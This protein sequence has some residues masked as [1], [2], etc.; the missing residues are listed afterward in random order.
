LKVMK[1]KRQRRVSA[2]VLGSCMPMTNGAR[3]CGGWLNNVVDSN[4]VRES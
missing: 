4:H 3:E 2:A 1:A